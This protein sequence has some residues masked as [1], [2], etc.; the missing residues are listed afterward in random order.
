MDFKAKY[1]KYKQK[2]L[3]LKKIIGGTINHTI[4]NESYPETLYDIFKIVYNMSES[5]EYQDV[6]SREEHVVQFMLNFIG[7]M[8]NEWNLR[9]MNNVYIYTERNGTNKLF[10]TQLLDNYIQQYPYNELNLRIIDDVFIYT[11][12]D[13]TDKLF[14]NQTLDNYIAQFPEYENYKYLLNP[15]DSDINL[16]ESMI[17]LML[18]IGVNVPILDYFNRHIN[19]SMTFIIDFQ[20]IFNILIKAY[21]SS[22][23]FGNED[24]STLRTVA[25]KNIARFCANRIKENHF[26]IIIVKPSEGLLETPDIDMFRELFFDKGCY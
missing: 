7:Y 26:V 23:V 16:V 13:R 22:S 12:R 2:Y 8:K 10:N 3:N 18:N 21:K 17:G 20:N 15:N 24:D 25:V 11:D 5:M 14:D 6:V 1:L 9:I 4:F 19:T